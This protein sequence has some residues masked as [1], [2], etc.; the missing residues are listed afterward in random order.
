MND[1]GPKVRE[2]LKMAD[3]T[4]LRWGS[5]SH[6]I[7]SDGEKSVSVPVKI[8]VRHTANGILKKA[9]LKKAF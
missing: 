4:H 8:K 7:Y 6:E 1:Y 5:G 9:G 2:L 3:F